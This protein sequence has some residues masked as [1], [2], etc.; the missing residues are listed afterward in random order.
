MRY[1]I[2]NNPPATCKTEVYEPPFDNPKRPGVE[3]FLTLGIAV[4]TNGLVWVALSGQ[5]RSR[6]LRPAQMQGPAERSHRD[7]PALPRGLDALPGSGPEVQGNRHSGG[8]LL[9]QLARPL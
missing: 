2:G 1:E 5:Q 6:Q 8:L 3:A 7:G 9:S 4:D